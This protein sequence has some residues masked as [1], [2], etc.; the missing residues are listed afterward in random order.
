M[1]QNEKKF[2]RIP[3][4]LLLTP[5]D[6][7]SSRLNPDYEESEISFD[8]GA[9]K[10]IMEEMDKDETSN[11]NGY[12]ADEIST[13]SSSPLVQVLIMEEK[14]RIKNTAITNSL[15]AFSL[16][17]QK[18]YKVSPKNQE[19][20][21]FNY[22]NLGNYNFFNGN[23]SNQ[24]V[25]RKK[26]KISQIL[27]KKWTTKLPSFVE[28]QKAKLISKI[29][30]I[31]FQKIN[32]DKNEHEKKMSMSYFQENVNNRKSKKI[33]FNFLVTHP[34]LS[35]KG[36]DRDY[37]MMTQKDCSKYSNN[38]NKFNILD[39]CDLNSLMR[40]NH[41]QNFNEYNGYSYSDANNFNFNNFHVN[42]SNLNNEHNHY[43]YASLHFK[44]EKNS[45]YKKKNCK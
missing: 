36:L 27:K 11:E 25:R 10:G 33:Q 17:T 32:Q 7:F 16:P 38:S 39:N 34:S 3:N 13:K 44:S 19:G 12:D 40:L 5:V 41:R 21:L 14:N 4:N 15:E 9:L 45:V 22:S 37:V 23:A 26:I 43:D 24:P 35:T 30:L 31:N 42:D 8:F 29:N 18:N 28:N 1:S 6:G 20:P 2:Q